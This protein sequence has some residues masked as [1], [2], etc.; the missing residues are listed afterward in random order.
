VR[1]AAKIDANQPEIVA[2][3]RKAGAL[4]IPTH[5]VGGG[6]P[7]L[8]VCFRGQTLLMEVKDGSKP[9]SARLLTPDQ[10][11]FHAA[12]IG[13]PLSIVQDVEGALRALGLMGSAQVAVGG[14]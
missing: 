2:A 3:L 9:P 10:L 11:A 7:D 12:W 13:G 8:V 5:M 4:V 6:F 1:R 14:K